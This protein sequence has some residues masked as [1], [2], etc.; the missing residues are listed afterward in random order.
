[1]NDRPHIKVILTL[2]DTTLEVLGWIS[3][4]VS[5]VLTI[6]YYASL[7]DIIPIHYNLTG[8]VDGFG[9]KTSI[10]TL[11]IV[12]TIIFIGLTIL[13]K[14]PHVFNYPTGIT[15]ANALKQYTTATR[16]IRY[17]KVIIVVVFACITLLTIKNANGELSGLGAWFLP[18]VLF[19]I[20]IPLVYFVIK[21][22]KP[23]KH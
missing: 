10:L 12:S 18:I 19:L 17:L 21:L 8:H 6:T 5:W 16:L 22:G 23:K 13:N 2:F 15:A 3:V 20:F 9:S 4:F 11:P 1:M 14:F 7:P